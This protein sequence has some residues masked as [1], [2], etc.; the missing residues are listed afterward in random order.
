MSTILVDHYRYKGYEYTNLDDLLDVLER[1]GISLTK[2]Q[3]P[4]NVGWRRQF[5]AN[6][7]VDWYQSEKEQDLNQLTISQ[8]KGLSN[9]ANA[10]DVV[11][12]K[13][14]YIDSV[15]RRIQYSTLNEIVFFYHAWCLDET[16]DNKQ[17]YMVADELSLTPNEIKQLIAN[18]SKQ[19]AVL[20]AKRNEATTQIRKAVTITAVNNAIV[21]FTN[22][23]NGLIK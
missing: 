14:I 20:I 7:N 19:Y 21:D 9:V 10:Y 17:T 12:N 15:D 18:V 8:F 5:W 2:G 6:H 11:K 22:Y 23:C 3:V 4:D 13:G 16:T 1:D